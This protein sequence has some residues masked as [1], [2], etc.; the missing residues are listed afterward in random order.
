MLSRSNTDV[1]ATTAR[2]LRRGLVALG[3]AAA[4]PASFATSQASAF[5]DASR[6][7]MDDDARCVVVDGSVTY[8]FPDG[9]TFNANATG[10]G[11]TKGRTYQG[12]DGKWRDIGPT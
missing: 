5:H 9:H 8:G 12:D 4:L 7:D 2:R 10:N 3:I 1:P 11:F 6:L